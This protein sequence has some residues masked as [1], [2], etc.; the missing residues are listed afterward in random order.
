MTMIALYCKVCFILLTKKNEPII[1]ENMADMTTYE[2]AT[3]G[4]ENPTS[5]SVWSKFGK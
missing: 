1:P 5:L 3:P 4:L 2:V